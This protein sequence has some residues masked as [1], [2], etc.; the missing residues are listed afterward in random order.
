MC[1]KCLVSDRNPQS[2]NDADANLYSSCAGVARSH[3][4]VKPK[5]VQGHL[6]CLPP[7]ARVTQRK[8]LRISS[9]YVAPHESGTNLGEG[10][11]ET[12]LRKD[13]HARC[14]KH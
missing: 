13:L 10:M 14:V 8:I 7:S 12:V 4:K 1:N 2:D 9:S 5:M 6:I 11:F 3:A